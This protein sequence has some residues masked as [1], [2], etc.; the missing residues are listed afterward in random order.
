MIFQILHFYFNLFPCSLNFF[1][2]LFEIFLPLLW[3]Q[4]SFCCNLILLHRQNLPTRSSCSMAILIV[5]HGLIPYTN[6]RR[7]LNDCR[8][9]PYNQLKANKWDYKELSNYYILDNKQKFFLKIFQCLQNL[10]MLS[11]C[12]NILEYNYNND[13]PNK[14]TNVMKSTVQNIN[15]TPIKQ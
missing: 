15:S 3:E 6:K 14:M 12:I 2:S 1:V 5:D 11:I 13:Q 8:N 9:N 7:K 10:E 4:I